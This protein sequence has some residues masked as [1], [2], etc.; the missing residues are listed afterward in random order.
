MSKLYGLSSASLFGMVIL[1]KCGRASVGLNCTVKVTLPLAVT[2]LDGGTVTVKAA[3]SAPPI[4]T[5]GTPPRIR[6]ASP[7][8]WMVN[9]WLTGVPPVWALPKSVSSPGS[10]V[11]SPSK[12]CTPLPST[13]ISGAAAAVPVPLMS[14]S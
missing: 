9:V 8:L 4:I 1:A 7:L 11:M 6:S 14:K 10:G 12:I 2:G 13:R 3:A 5:S